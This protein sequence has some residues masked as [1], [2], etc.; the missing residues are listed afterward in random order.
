MAILGCGSNS[1]RGGRIRLP[2]LPQSTH[3]AH[4]L[5][6]CCT[7]LHRFAQAGAPAHSRVWKWLKARFG[8]HIEL[9]FRVSETENALRSGSRSICPSCG[10]AATALVSLSLRCGPCMSTFR[11]LSF[12]SNTNCFVLRK[13]YLDGPPAEEVEMSEEL[14]ERLEEL[15]CQASKSWNQR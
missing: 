1:N 3:H 6:P 5:H 8:Q 7:G 4:P 11:A 15:G 14:L 9:L 10:G 2:A 12:P 13:C